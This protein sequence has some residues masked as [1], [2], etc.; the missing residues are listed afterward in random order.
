MFVDIDM[1]PF[2]GVSRQTMTKEKLSIKCYP[3]AVTFSEVGYVVVLADTC[4]NGGFDFKLGTVI[5]YASRS[6]LELSPETQDRQFVDKP[7][8]FTVGFPFRWISMV[9][10]HFNHGHPLGIT[11]THSSLNAS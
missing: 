3:A 11:P 5:V 8:Y 1:F 4:S 10:S 6:S 7:V 2:F 9:F